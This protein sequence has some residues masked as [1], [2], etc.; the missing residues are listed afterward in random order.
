MS[1]LEG[2]VE[3]LPELI[4]NLKKLPFMKHNWFIF[5]FIQISKINFDLLNEV[6]KQIEKKF[7]LS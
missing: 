1:I 7:I 3:T 6:L 2:K 5:Q 4:E